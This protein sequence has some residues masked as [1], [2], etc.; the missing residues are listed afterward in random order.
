[1]IDQ[2]ERAR[3]SAPDRARVNFN[4]GTWIFFLLICCVW[5][6]W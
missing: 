4:F 5:S 3:S 6:D 2:S 1:M